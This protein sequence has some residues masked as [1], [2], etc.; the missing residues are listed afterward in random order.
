MLC[1]AEC[2]CPARGGRCRLAMREGRTTT[3]AGRQRRFPR[4]KRGSRHESAWGATIMQ[5]CQ[6]GKT[7]AR[8][9]LSTM[10]CARLHC[11]GIARSRRA[12]PSRQELSA[13]SLCGLDAQSPLRTQGCCGLL[14]ARMQNLKQSVLFS[15]RSLLNKE[16]SKLTVSSSFSAICW[17]IE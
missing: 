10:T 5:V 9:A 15:P 14:H 13:R 7:D 17:E 8:S 12:F 3:C 11:G 1:I 2:G 16:T 6:Q 4:G